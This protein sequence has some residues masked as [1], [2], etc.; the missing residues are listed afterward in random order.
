MSENCAIGT[1]KF[2]NGDFIVIEP[3]TGE[4]LRWRQPDGTTG[5]LSKTAGERWKST[6]GWTGRPDGHRISFDCDDDG[7]RF[8]GQQGERIAFDVTETH[9]EVDGAI[10]AGRL[11]MP[12]SN[13][14]VPVVVLIHG[15]EHSS[16]R[17]DYALQRMFPAAGIGVFVYDKRGTGASAGEYT[18][19]YATLATDAV[20]AL[21]EARRIGGP[22][23]LRIGYQ[24]GSQGGWVA[25]LAARIEPVD[26][27]IVSFGLAVSVVAAEHE[28][29]SAE[30]SKHGFGPETAA[31]AL[32]ISR[33][34]ETLVDSN[35]Q[36]GYEQ[37]EQVRARYRNEP[38]FGY[39]R[40]SFVGMILDM[41]PDQL[42]H[43]ASALA[44][45]ISLYYDP[46]PVLRNLDVPQL[47]LLASD[48]VI[49][50]S[51]ETASRL[52]K[53]KQTGRPITTVVFAGADH[54]MYRY[55]LAPDGSRVS[56]RTPE[57][58]FPMMRD[59]ILTGRTAPQ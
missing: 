31:K 58:Y 48:D 23:I 56:T 30:L 52:A 29:I 26:F 2:A 20:A 1:Y 36:T 13:G 24:G 15:A 39:V 11:V 42:R 12:R 55:E 33:A 8:D 10:L 16:A 7:L 47:W 25:P 28:L 50:P 14:P 43:E 19:D 34:V 45:N 53:L 51:A 41:S 49:A 22:R 9:F 46:M 27:V 6:L 4:H 54:G 37:L 18:Q 57:T 3:G 32:E 35:F 40:G 59:F 5:E 21:H 38:W 17:Q 44:P